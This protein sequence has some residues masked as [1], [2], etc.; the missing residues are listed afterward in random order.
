MYRV[1]YLAVNI[2]T[3]TCR[4]YYTW[5][6]MLVHISFIFIRE[7]GVAGRDSSVSILF[8]LFHRETV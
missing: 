4:V 8:C 2:F 7:W 3:I 5:N 6:S 1:C